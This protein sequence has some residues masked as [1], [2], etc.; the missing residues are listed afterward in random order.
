MDALFIIDQRRTQIA[1]ETPAERKSALGQF[2]TPTAIARFMSS[3]FTPLGKQRIHLLDAGAGIGSLTAAFAAKALHDKAKSLD[4]EAWEIDPALHD[5][6]TE[7]LHGCQD[8]FQGAKIPFHFDLRTED[9]IEAVP[10]QV[11]TH[12]ILNPPYKKI[13]SDSRHR[14]SLRQAGIES[15]NLYSA[16]VALALLSLKDGGELV[17]ITPRSFCNGTYFKPFRKLILEQATLTHVH[18]FGSRDHAFKGDDV[19]QENVIFHLIKGKAQGEVV[20]S[21][22]LNASFQDL[23]QR[24]VPFSSVVMPEDP[25][26][27]FYLVPEGEDP[28]IE[29]GV[30]AYTHSLED[31]GLTVST[32]PVVDFR[33]R[34]VLKQDM[35]Q[36]CVPLVY[37]FHFVNGFVSHPKAD[38]KKPNAILD[39]EETLKWLMPSGNYVIVRRLTSKEEKRRIVPAVFDSKKVHG[40][41]IGFENHLNVFHAKKHGLPP[42][43]AKGLAVYLGSTLADQWFR[44]FNGHTQVNAGDLRAMRY[45]DLETLIE[46]GS[47]VK[48]ALPS[49]QQIDALVE[50]KFNVQ[51]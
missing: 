16:F 26:S 30:K 21:S 45:P 43:V 10:A 39:N 27:I 41:R 9:F 8:A 12:A 2:M 48:D 7:T 5:P 38:S 19:L 14:K 49:Q 25:D 3:L 17:A 31:L 40:E 34:S 44:R 24:T 13:N 47:Q 51:D 28:M 29:A 33:M 37:P 36:G 6:L 35:E 4:A 50:G 42:K 46:W 20:I 22:C 1:S 15:T 11:F 32:G 18:V 23:T